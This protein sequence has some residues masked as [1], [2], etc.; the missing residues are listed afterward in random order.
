Y[1][2]RIALLSATVATI[3]SLAACF[4]LVRGGAPRARDL[5]NLLLAPLIV[6]S[7]IYA[8]AL[9]MALARL[10]TQPG[11]WALTAAMTVIGVPFALRVTLSAFNSLDWQLEGAARTLG[12]SRSESWRLVLIP[13]IAP[14]IVTGWLFSFIVAFDES[15]ISIFLATPRQ[16]TL[17]A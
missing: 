4:A 2:L 11:Y 14:S 13:I 6:P 17:S 10:Q 9:V 16:Q 12:A 5:S 8:L 7:I 15:V 3:I 1:S